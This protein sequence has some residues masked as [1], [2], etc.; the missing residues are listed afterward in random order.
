MEQYHLSIL[1]SSRL[2]AKHMAVGAKWPRAVRQ[3]SELCTGP[4][5]TQRQGR[6]PCVCPTLLQLL[7]TVARGDH[8]ETERYIPENSPGTCPVKQRQEKKQQKSIGDWNQQL[9]KLG[10]KGMRHH[11][12]NPSTQEAL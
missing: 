7:S 2:G 10:I 11:A 4:G 5:D 9:K 1:G 12:L 8:M 3:N 6:V